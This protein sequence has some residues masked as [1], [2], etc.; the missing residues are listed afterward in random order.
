VQIPWT[1]ASSEAHGAI[2]ADTHRQLPIDTVHNDGAAC[3]QNA[4][5]LRHLRQQRTACGANK[6]YA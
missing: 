2:S 5:P 1:L 3:P 4:R 6:S